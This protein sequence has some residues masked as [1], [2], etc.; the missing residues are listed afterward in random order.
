[1]MDN[2]PRVASE[3]MTDPDPITEKRGQN[4]IM[5]PSRPASTADQ[6]SSRTFSRSTSAERMT[7]NSGDA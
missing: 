7:M 1:M 3:F 4:T 6:R 2:A 5:T